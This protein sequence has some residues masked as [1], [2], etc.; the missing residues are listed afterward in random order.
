MGTP[1]WPHGA[2]PE[3]TAFE[4]QEAELTNQTVFRTLIESHGG[5]DSS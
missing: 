2:E 4:D 1:L 5:F 3:N